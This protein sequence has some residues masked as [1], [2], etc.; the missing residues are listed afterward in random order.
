M[1]V[2]DLGFVDLFLVILLEFLKWLYYEYKIPNT[3]KL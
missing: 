2:M 3:S 1:V